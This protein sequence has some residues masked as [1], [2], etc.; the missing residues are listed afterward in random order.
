MA[1]MNPAYEPRT[2]LG[3]QVR[4][5]S[6]KAPMARGRVRVRNSATVKH[7]ITGTANRRL[8]HRAPWKR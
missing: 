5:P 1:G 8:T 7:R 6:A 3:K 2:M 4:Y